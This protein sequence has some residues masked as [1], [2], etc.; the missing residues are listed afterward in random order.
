LN[1][2]AGQEDVVERFRRGEDPYL[3]MAS[4]YHGRPIEKKDPERQDGK[5]IELAC[6]YGMGGLKL[7][8]RAKAQ[9]TLMDGEK[10]VKVYRDGHPFV[11]RLW[12]EAQW[13]LRQLHD[14]KDFT[15]RI[16]QGRDGK[17]C[18]PNGTW[19]N[20]EGMFWEDGEYRLRGRRGGWSKMY[21]SK[22]V[23][24]VIQWLSRIVTCEAM[25]RFKAAGVPIVGMA[26]DDVWLLVIDPGGIEQRKELQRKIIAMM[27]VEPIWAPGLPLAADC[28]LGVTYS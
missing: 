7:T 17:L 5:V 12:N 16:F 3:P 28:K 22:L 9:G 20:Y 14:K 10:G 6:G 25:M 24:N 1:W 23:E 18:H 19:L 21:G 8:A 4:A 2:L 11:V 13:A 27:A 26:H 15:W